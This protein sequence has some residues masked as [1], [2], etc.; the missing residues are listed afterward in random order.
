ME[1]I[2]K[3]DNKKLFEDEVLSFSA[4]P[5]KTIFYSINWRV[6]FNVN[7]YKLYKDWRIL[8]INWININSNNIWKEL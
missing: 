8:I 6:E 1:V 4:L 2:L 5:H 7:N 3:V